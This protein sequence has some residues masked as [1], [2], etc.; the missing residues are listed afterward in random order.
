[1]LKALEEVDVSLISPFI[2]MNFV[3]SYLLG[4]VF[5]GESVTR[6]KL[7]GIT[8]VVLCVLLLSEEALQRIS[9]LW[10]YLRSGGPE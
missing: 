8:I 2:Q 4:V 5:L 7:L 10:T 9:E 6:R 1:M 3:L